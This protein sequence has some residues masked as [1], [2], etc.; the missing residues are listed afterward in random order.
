MKRSGF[1]QKQIIGVLK[2]HQAEATAPDLCRKHGV[3]DATF[4]KRRS[5]YGE[6]EV[7]DAKRLRG[8]E[9]V[10][11]KRFAFRRE[12]QAEEAA[13]GVDAGRVDAA[14]EAGK[15][16][17]T[18]GLRRTAVTWAVQ[19]RGY[20]QRQACKLVGIEPKTC[21]YVSRRPDDGAVRA[22]LRALAGER[23]RFGY[24]R[25]HILLA[26][27]GLKLNHKRLF[28][29]CRESDALASGRRFRVLAVVDDFTRECPG[30][31]ADTSLSGLRVGRELDQVAE[32]RGCRPATIVSDNGT[33]LTSHAILRWQE[34]RAVLR[35][36]IAPGKPQQN[37]FV[38]SFN[39]RFRD[40]CL[41]EHLLSRLAAARQIIE[42]WRIDYNTER[43]HTSLDGITPEAF[44][45]RPKPGHTKKDSPHQRG[46]IGGR[47][48]TDG[49]AIADSD[50][51]CR[52]GLTAP[53]HRCVAPNEPSVNRIIPSL[54][55]AMLK[56]ASVTIPTSP[57]ATAPYSR[58]LIVGCC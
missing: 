45:T 4:Y 29:I 18:P 25:L 6:M 54:H 7:S 8:L 15:K 33:E 38:E 34:K 21:R 41:N 1:T 14:G 27:D 32:R 50:R 43:P 47:V 11:R 49:H 52:S 22:R 42:T 55:G 31:V 35:H 46:H 20:S 16:L 56:R 51:R 36:Y 10:S 19:Q 23:R 3:S 37:G 9:E 26:R 58:R 24:R 30:L 2:E 39:G 17:M 44:A 13:G 12:R 57:C 48:N 53:S 40:E 28:R 5:K